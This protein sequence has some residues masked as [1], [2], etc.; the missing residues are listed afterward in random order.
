MASNKEVDVLKL[1]GK[2]SGST[3]GS[4]V[5]P[6]VIQSDASNVPNTVKL[7]GSNY[8]LWSKVLEMHIAGRGK[9][10]F[11]TGSI[12]EPDED[13]VDYDAWETG[14]AIVKGWLINSMDPTL[15][16]FFIHLRTAQ[17]V[18]EEVAR[19][20]Y[21]GSDISQIYEL[22]E[23]KK[24]LRAK[25]RAS[26]GASGRRPPM[27][28]ATTGNKDALPTQGDPSWILDSGATDHMT[29]DKRLFKYMT[30]THQKC[31][32]TANGTTAVV[33][34]AGTVDLTPSLSLHHCLLVPSLSHNLLSIPQVTEQL[35]CVV[36]MYPFFC[37]LQDIQTKEIIGRG[38]KREGLYYVD[39]VV[40][41][42][43]NAIRASRTSHL[44]EVW[45]LHRRLGHVSF[46]Y[47]R[48]MLPSMFHEIKESDLHCEVCILAKSH[49]ASFP[50]SMNK[51]LLPFELVHSDVWGPSPVNTVSGVK[52]FVTFI[53]DCTRMT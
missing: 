46:G 50:S 31:V 6:V 53:D 35:D 11:V 19:T 15:M 10:G 29:F 12:K 43:A 33:T 3:H 4:V 41:G 20:Y 51:S 49:R 13:S 42:R 22:K 30:T 9:K 7:N 52:W 25:E 27:V 38:T 1:E 44:Q 5:N 40:P 37:L 23:L 47:L 34:G 48:R 39:D 21:D 14:N 16:G 45:L 28:A 36:L 24:K 18:W 8:S 2:G 32:A 17:E 26:S